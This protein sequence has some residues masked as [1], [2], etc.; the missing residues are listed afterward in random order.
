MKS[1][2]LSGSPCGFLLPPGTDPHPHTVSQ[3][4]QG[5]HFGELLS[6]PQPWEGSSDALVA[7][8][9][10]LPVCRGAFSARLDVLNQAL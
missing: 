2:E 4:P 5:G 10:A 7:A 9:S 1:G 3:H 6:L 8:T